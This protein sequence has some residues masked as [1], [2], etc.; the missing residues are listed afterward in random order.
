LIMFNQ[1]IHEKE[2]QKITDRV[3]TVYTGKQKRTKRI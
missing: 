2:I 1:K 3:S